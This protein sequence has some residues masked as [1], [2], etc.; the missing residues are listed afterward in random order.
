M[1]K[2]ECST[3]TINECLAKRVLCICNV[4]LQH[5]LFKNIKR[6]E[7]HEFSRFADVI[8]LDEKRILFFKGQKI[9]KVYFLLSLY[10]RYIFPVTKKNYKIDNLNSLPL[11]I[12]IGIT[13]SYEK[14]E[15]TKEPIN[16]I[17]DFIIDIEAMK[18]FRGLL[19]EFY[20]VSQYNDLLFVLLYKHK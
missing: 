9:D 7:T 5:P 8:D 4:I 1:Y 17:D 3:Q 19:T 2:Q 11:N 13:Y 15:M 18:Y 10:K 20:S 16:Q 14:Y 12:K 6:E